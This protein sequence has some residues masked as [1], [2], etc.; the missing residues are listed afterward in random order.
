MMNN[1]IELK[2][3]NPDKY[4]VVELD[5]GI[6]FVHDDKNNKNFF[7][8]KIIA[9][10]CGTNESNVRRYWKNFKDKRT[11]VSKSHVSIMIVNSDKP[12]DFK[13]FDFFNYVSNRVNTKEAL[14]MQE[15]IANAID[16]KFNKDIG[17]KQPKSLEQEAM[18]TIKYL[19][20]KV[21]E[22]TK[23]AFESQKHEDFI[24]H[25][26]LADKYAMDSQKRRYQLRNELNCSKRLKKECELNLKG[27]LTESCELQVFIPDNQ[28]TLIDFKLSIKEVEKDE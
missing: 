22:E 24:H 3:N 18:R 16:E 15:Y 23:K 17:F 19:E 10:A 9:Q 4:V 5:N 7:S 26:D 1:M 8:N 14:Q 25:M 6:C 20:N 21:W 13:G 2:S 11:N 28:S 12:V 27:F